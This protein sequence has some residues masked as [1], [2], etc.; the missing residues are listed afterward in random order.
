MLVLNDPHHWEG[1][2]TGMDLNVAGGFLI[3]S[4]S[5]RFRLKLSVGS[6]TEAVVSELYRS[7]YNQ[8]EPSK[9]KVLGLTFRFPFWLY[10]IPQTPP[11]NTLSMLMSS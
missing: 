5:L 7:V 10:L 1:F 2:L 9:A 8:L 3:L 4:R 11:L 6:G